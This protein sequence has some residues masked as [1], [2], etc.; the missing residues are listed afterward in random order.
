MFIFVTVIFVFKTKTYAN[1]FAN[2]VHE[3]ASGNSWSY[4]EPVL[5]WILKKGTLESIVAG[6]DA[7]CGISI[8]ESAKTQNS[9]PD[10][11]GVGSNDND[12]RARRKKTK[13][14]DLGRSRVGRRGKWRSWPAT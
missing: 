10:E 9:S 4:G 5:A 1:A 3:H 12:K 11:S 14:K 13:Q 7:S 2:H 8:Q 6:V